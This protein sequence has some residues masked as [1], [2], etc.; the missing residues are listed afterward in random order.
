MVAGIAFV[1]VSLAL[2]GEAASRSGDVAVVTRGTAGCPSAA[3]VAAELGRLAGSS[4]SRGG[5]DRAE[6]DGE[7]TGLR[8]RLY[9]SD[10]TLVG[11]RTIETAADCG[12][13]A[14]AAAVVIATWEATLRSDVTLEL[15]GVGAETTP[16]PPEPSRWSL[17]AAAHGVGVASA[18][19]AWTPGGAVDFQLAHARGFGLRGA[20]WGAGF[21]SQE[22]GAE[23]GRVRWARWA[24][25]VGPSYQRAAGS[26]LLSLFGQLAVGQIFVGGEGFDRTFSDWSADIGAGGGIEVGLARAGLS[27]V[28]G[29]GAVVWP[30][31]QQAVAIG[32]QDTV[33]LPAV[34]MLVSLGLRWN[35]RSPR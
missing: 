3:G 9:R 6:V 32:V 8:V 24:V 7:P 4:A 22:L 11:E 12:E 18:A 33:E 28:L 1:F 16:P 31:S 5:T 15:H 23:S 21:R 26:V 13:R 14:A 19:D 29:V 20:I 34:D 17:S 25:G 35:S 27:P 10:A 2:D 30:G